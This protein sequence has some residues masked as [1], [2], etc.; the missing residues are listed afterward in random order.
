MR[1][2]QIN[3]DIGTESPPNVTAGTLKSRIKFKKKSESVVKK[4][5]M[6][7]GSSET[8]DRIK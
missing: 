2:L 4:E 8:R 3:V 6:P 7:L 1:R 5:P